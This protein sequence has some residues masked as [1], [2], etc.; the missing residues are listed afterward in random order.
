MSPL[1]ERLILLRE[2]H[3]LPQR[4][5]AEA[6]QITMR[7]YQR[8]E[9]GDGAT[10]FHCNRAGKILSYFIGRTGLWPKEIAGSPEWQRLPMSSTAKGSFF[11]K[12]TQNGRPLCFGKDSVL[13][14]NR[15]TSKCGGCMNEYRL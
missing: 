4:T 3:R 1:S 9:Y 15:A 7:A 10:A 8:Y 5:V 11:Y 13:C 2:Q 6:I 14:V 12:N